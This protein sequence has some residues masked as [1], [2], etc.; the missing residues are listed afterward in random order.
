MATI[1]CYGKSYTVDH[2]VKGADYVH[3]YNADGE[4]VVSL[5]GVRDFS[6]ITYSGSYIS[7]SICITEACNDIKFCEG[8]FK[9]RDGRTVYIPFTAFEHGESLPNFGKVDRLFLKKV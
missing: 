8:V 6:E 4:L 2:A 5:E 9:T 7:P 3:G 1:T